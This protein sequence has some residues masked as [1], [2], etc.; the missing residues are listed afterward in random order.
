MLCE[1]ASNFPPLLARILERDIHIKRNFREETA[2]D[3]LTAGLVG[4]EPFGIRVDYP[5]EPTTGAD[6][7]WIY[8]APNEIAGGSYLRLVIQAKRAKLR[9][10]ASGGYW[11][12]EHL[13]H[14]T[15][16]GDQANTL[17]NYAASKPDGMDTL[18]LHMFYHPLS[19]LAPQTRFKPAIEGINATFAEDV[20]VVVN[21]GCGIHQ[22]KV[23]YWRDGFLS[24]AD[25]LCFPTIPPVGPLPDPL[26]PDGVTLFLA[27]SEPRLLRYPA[28]GCHPLIIADRLN[29]V[30]RSFLRPSASADS[31]SDDR[32]V[33]PSFQIPDNVRAAIAGD[34]S[35]SDRK[36][37]KRPRL[38]FST[39]QTSNDPD[40][41]EVRSAAQRERR[42]R[43][44]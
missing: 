15:P 38:I 22:K 5:D 23:A 33:R 3:L 16:P 28:M 41:E 6:M 14:G 19:A 2:T 8:A 36:D 4:L 10:T 25:L 9:P 30:R 35:K 32:S 11:L 18:A 27:G 39:P 31:G 24:L 7:D 13:D 21:G 34:V 44:G 42:G 17:V 12:Y 1:F 43:Q 40:F 37:L 20:A 29:A 26:F